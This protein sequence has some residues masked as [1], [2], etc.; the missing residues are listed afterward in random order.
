MQLQ[1]KRL[2]TA[3]VPKKSVAPSVGSI[4]IDSVEDKNNNSTYKI[5]DNTNEEVSFCEQVESNTMSPTIGNTDK[6]G[7]KSSEVSPREEVQMSSIVYNTEGR[8]GNL[9]SKGSNILI[10]HMLR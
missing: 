4:N 8:I 2:V 3:L 9:Q 5:H 6:K 1:G 10:V 7:N